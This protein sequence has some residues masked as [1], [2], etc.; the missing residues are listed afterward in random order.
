MARPRLRRCSL[1]VGVGLAAAYASVSDFTGVIHSYCRD[2]STAGAPTPVPPHASIRRP[3]PLVSR[4]VITRTEGIDDSPQPGTRKIRPGHLLL[5]TEEPCHLDPQDLLEVWARQRQRFAEVLRGFGPDDWAA[6]TRCADW[7]AHD[8]VRHLCDCNAIAAGTYE[9][10]LDLAAGFDPRITPRGW[11]TVSA[12]QSPGATF[13]CFQATTGELLALLRDR[14]AQGL[15]FDVHLP[16]GPM[17]WT[18]LALHGFWDS[19]LHERDVLLAQGRDHPTDGDATSYAAAYGLFIAAAVAALFGEP[20]QDKLT[21]S[22]DGGGV[23]DLDSRDGVTLTAT[24]VTTAGPPAAEVTDALAGRPPAAAALGDLPA[25]S[26][27]AL[28]RMANFFNTP[29]QPSPP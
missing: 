12:D 13:S 3:E 17:D 14:L 29:V 4:P 22:G 5:R 2:N 20:V 9:H 6:P 25:S 16:Y 10:A 21:L 23:F 26:R 18:I 11:P 8:V 27:A 15:R 28:F 1:A 7:T 19:W 24:R